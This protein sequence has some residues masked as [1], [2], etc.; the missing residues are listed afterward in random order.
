MLINKIPI[1]GS[2]L[3][4]KVPV[5]RL[6]KFRLRDSFFYDFN[7]LKVYYFICWLNVYIFAEYG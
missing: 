7:W 1:V 3:I 2:I 6:L 4:F 5:A